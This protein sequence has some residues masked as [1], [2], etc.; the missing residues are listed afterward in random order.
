MLAALLLRACSNVPSMAN[1]NVL[2]PASAKSK[3][4][5][6]EQRHLLVKA[7][8]QEVHKL[9]AVGAVAEEEVDALVNFLDVRALLVRAVL[10]NELL[11]EHEGALVADVLPHLQRVILATCIVGDMY[12]A[13]CL[14]MLACF[15]MQQMSYVHTATWPRYCVP[16]KTC[17]A[18]LRSSPAETQARHW[19]Y[20]ECARSESGPLAAAAHLNHGPPCVHIGVGAIA[21]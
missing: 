17:V 13:G 12:C 5:N 2:S 15:K 6:T 4:V 21:I 18:L 10:E 8:L 14:R 20:S 7:C 9:L 19:K 16:H 3:H 11:K 1:N